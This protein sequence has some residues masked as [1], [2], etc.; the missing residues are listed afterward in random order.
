MGSGR[1]LLLLGVVD[2]EGILL[3]GGDEGRIFVVRGLRIEVLGRY[4]E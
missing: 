1:F 3:V 2:M 4:M